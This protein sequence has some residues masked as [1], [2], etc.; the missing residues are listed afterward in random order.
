M[1]LDAIMPRDTSQAQKAKSHMMMMMVVVVMGHECIWET[2]LGDQQK[3][4][5]RKGF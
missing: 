5:G 3:E 4:R 2:I 1:E